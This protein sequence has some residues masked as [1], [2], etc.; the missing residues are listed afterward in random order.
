MSMELA[1]T[2][3]KVSGGNL[4]NV[5]RDGRKV[6][7]LYRFWMSGDAFTDGRYYW[8][9]ALDRPMRSESFKTFREAKKFVEGL[10]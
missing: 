2:G 1:A 5:N 8:Q 4:Y 6:G 9:V 10:E 7:E 3:F